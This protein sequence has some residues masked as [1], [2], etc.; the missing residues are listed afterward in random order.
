M[1]FLSTARPLAAALAL[2][3]LGACADRVNAPT[4]AVAAPSLATSSASTSPAA[5]CCTARRG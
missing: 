3:A 2:L 4:E 5:G 1:R